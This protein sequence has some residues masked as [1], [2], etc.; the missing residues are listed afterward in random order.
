MALCFESGSN[1]RVQPDRI[2]SK[3][4]LKERVLVG[5]GSIMST[6][7]RWLD[8][9]FTMIACAASVVSPA[10]HPKCS[11]ATCSACIKSKPLAFVEILWTA[12]AKLCFAPYHLPE[13]LWR[14]IFSPPCSHNRCALRRY[15]SS[16]P[17]WYHVLG[18]F[19]SPLER[20]FDTPQQP[21]TPFPFLNLPLEL[22]INIYQHVSQADIAPEIQIASKWRAG[23]STPHYCGNTAATR[24][25]AEH[26]A[27][28]RDTN[29]RRSDRSED[30]VSYQLNDNGI[31]AVHSSPPPM[32]LLLVNRQIYEEVRDAFLS[33]ASFEVQ[34]LTPNEACWRLDQNMTAT[35]EAIAKS[36]YAKWMRKVRIRIDVS[37]FSMGRRC[38][39]FERSNAQVCTFDEIRLFECVQRL[40]PLAKQLC[41]ALK[42]SAPGLK[43]VELHW[44][45]DFGSEVES[46]DLKSRAKILA[47]FVT[48]DGVE[49][50]ICKLIIA[51]E[52]RRIVLGMARDS[53]RVL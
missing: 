31:I 13:K 47:P 26:D 49:T 6:L 12:L 8:M 44:N 7:V 35:Y 52:G 37:R 46:E 43:V 16:P 36:K 39:R 5:F 53:L 27:A 23:I 1:G 45:D 40:Q 32:N 15:I 41:E 19:Y 24:P 50:Q 4:S 34:P 42:E 22:R 17:P 48:L 29:N 9:P 2:K 14:K 25:I 38:K 20:V 21:Q 28:G 33:T 30:T 18:P 3:I 10:A 51:S 11:C